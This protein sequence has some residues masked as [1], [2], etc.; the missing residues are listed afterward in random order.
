MTAMAFAVEE[1]FSLSEVAR[2]FGKR[3]HQTVGYAHRAIT[4]QAETD[5]I[6]LKKIRT[7]WEEIQES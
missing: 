2:N 6:F 3:C 4:D 7:I 1:G 5:P